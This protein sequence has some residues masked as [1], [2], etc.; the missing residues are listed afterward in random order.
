M[1]WTGPDVQLVLGARSSVVAVVEDKVV[2]PGSW[3]FP[4]R[5]KH[6]VS[7]CFRTGG[8]DADWS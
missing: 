2:S 6:V 8:R 5:R 7:M 4:E 1:T 3:A